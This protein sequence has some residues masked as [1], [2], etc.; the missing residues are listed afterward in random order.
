MYP[1]TDRS[2]PDALELFFNT[3]ITAAALSI[4]PAS[5]TS[6]GSPLPRSIPFVH[7]VA[8]SFAV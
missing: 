3:S 5:I 1:D 6:I 8:P 4:M 7:F 2:W